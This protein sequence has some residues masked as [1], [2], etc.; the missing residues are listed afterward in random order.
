MSTITIPPRSSPS[1]ARAAS[2]GNTGSGVRPVGQPSRNGRRA[3]AASRTPSAMS[4]ATRTPTSSGVATMLTDVVMGITLSRV[5]QAGGSGW[6]EGHSLRAPESIPE[7]N[8]RWKI[9]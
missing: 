4:P 5:L 9:T 6:V 7:M 2:A 8:F 3:D 1:A